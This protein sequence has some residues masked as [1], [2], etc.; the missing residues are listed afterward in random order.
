MNEESVSLWSK[1]LNEA[2]SQKKKK[3]KK[4]YN[5][6]SRYPF[7]EEITRPFKNLKNS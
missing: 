1:M 3:S 4:P 6:W 7:K 5:G 2:E